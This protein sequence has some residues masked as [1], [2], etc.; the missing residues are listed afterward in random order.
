MQLQFQFMNELPEI[1]Q[2]EVIGR[3]IGRLLNTKQ[4]AYGDSF[5]KQQEILKVLYPEG[6]EPWQYQNVLTIVRIL[7]KIFRIS[8]FPKTTNSDIMD[9][10]PWR[11]IAGYAILSIPKK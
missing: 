11:D 7:D 9:E 4:Q 5:G 10:D 6:I 1:S 3:E 8:N 2:Y